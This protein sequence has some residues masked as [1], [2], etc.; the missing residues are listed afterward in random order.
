[1][2]REPCIEESDYLEKQRYNKQKAWKQIGSRVCRLM[3][4]NEYT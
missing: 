2:N 1:M 3:D 4:N